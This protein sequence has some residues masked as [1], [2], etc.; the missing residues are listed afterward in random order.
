VLGGAFGAAV[1]L[2]HGGV[3][4][5]E[6]KKFLVRA[7]LHHGAGMKDNNLVGMGDGRQSVTTW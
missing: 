4:A 7:P 2:P 1:F 6:C 3:T 5:V